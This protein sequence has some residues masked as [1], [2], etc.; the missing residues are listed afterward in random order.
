MSEHHEPGNVVLLKWIMNNDIRRD[1]LCFILDQ[2]YFEFEY[3]L[4]KREYSNL[5]LEAQNKHFLF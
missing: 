2:K 5:T 1:L 3:L 4:M